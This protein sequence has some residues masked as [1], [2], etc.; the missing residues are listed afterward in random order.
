MYGDAAGWYSLLEQVSKRSLSTQDARALAVRGRQLDGDSRWALPL[1]MDHWLEGRYS[2]ALAALL[3]PAVAQASDPLWLYHNLV[4]M[5]ARKV[6]G[7]TARA[8]TAF[9]RSLELDPNRPDTLY[10]FANL[11]KDDDPERAVVLYRR[12]LVL[13]PSAASAWHNYGTALNSLT[14]YQEALGA[15]RLSLRL[16]PLVADV[17]CNLGLSYFGLEDFASAERAF[18]HAIALDASHAPSHT[19][20]G[21][22][23]ISVLQPEEALQY[24]ERGVELDQAPPTPCGTLPSPICCSVT[25]PRAGSTTRCFDNEDFEH[26]TIPPQGRA[27]V[28]WPM[29]H[30]LG[31]LPSLSGRSRVSVM[32]FSFAGT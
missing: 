6:D 28:I 1:A 30:R 9:E 14:Q 5:V 13:E 32:P 11:L 7:E 16:D 26:V 17:W 19:N 10:N 4:G 8:A 21:N 15:L 25:T 22:A 24:L 18:R 31:S 20:L 29:P 2:D 23:L 12:S 27:L 3:E